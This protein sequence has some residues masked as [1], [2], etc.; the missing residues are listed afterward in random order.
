MWVIRVYQSLHT[1]PALSG[2][3]DVLVMGGGGGTRDGCDAAC[4]R[5]VSSSPSAAV[6]SPLM[7]VSVA[8]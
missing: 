7:A 1:Y 8:G 5:T 6:P 2:S 3:A 4:T